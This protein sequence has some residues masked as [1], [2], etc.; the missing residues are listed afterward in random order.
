MPRLNAE[1]RRLRASAAAYAQWAATPD[2][3]ARTAKARASFLRRFEAEVDPEGQLD[4]V[5]R[6]SGSRRPCGRT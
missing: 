4:P 6:P 1:Q 3:T 5:M 2:W